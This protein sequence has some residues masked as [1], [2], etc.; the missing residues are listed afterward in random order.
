MAKSL[1]NAELNNASGGV[2]R[3]A[4]KEEKVAL[5]GKEGIAVEGM[6]RNGKYANMLFSQDKFGDKTLEKAYKFARDV[7]I[8]TDVNKATVE[9]G[10]DILK[11]YLK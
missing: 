4:N 9:N 11:D 8:S 2:I 7:G 3:N 5:G 1:N 10:S 6:M